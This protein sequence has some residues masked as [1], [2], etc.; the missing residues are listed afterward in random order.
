MYQGAETADVAR[1]ER[2]LESIALAA[3]RVNAATVNIASFL[4]RF[5]G[6]QP[7]PGTPGAKEPAPP[8]NYS[9]S[10]G[11]LFEALDR[12]ENRISALGEIG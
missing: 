5:H 11:R 2:P 7:E 3:Q 9:N 4:E 10:L 1:R 8:A 6:P 12:L